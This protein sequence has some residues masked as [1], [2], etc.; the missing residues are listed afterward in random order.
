[1]SPVITCVKR[2]FQGKDAVT[3]D[4]YA[5]LLAVVVIGAAVAIHLVGDKVSGFFGAVA[6]AV[7]SVL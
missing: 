1:M 3:V 4:E 2:L 6:Q 5:V 7:G